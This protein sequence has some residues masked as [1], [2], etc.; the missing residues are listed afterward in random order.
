MVRS[1]SHLVWGTKNE[2]AKCNKKKDR[3]GWFC[4]TGVGGRV[5]SKKDDRVGG[6]HSM[7]RSKSHLVWGNTFYGAI[8]IS[9][10]LG[11]NVVRLKS[12]LYLSYLE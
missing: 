3:G 7:V 8:E 10:C 11:K 1:K 6:I 9:S 5:R 12:H 2:K 4:R